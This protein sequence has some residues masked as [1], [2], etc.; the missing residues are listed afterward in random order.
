[1]DSSP[2]MNHSFLG[3]QGGMTCLW[4]VLEKDSNGGRVKEVKP[5]KFAN[6]WISDAWPAHL[7]LPGFLINIQKQYLI[8][9]K[10]MWNFMGIYRIFLLKEECCKATAIRCTGNVTLPQLQL[11]C[12]TS[13]CGWQGRQFY[14][15]IKFG[16]FFFF[17]FRS[18]SLRWLL[19]QKLWAKMTPPH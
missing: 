16:W 5:K 2:G 14:W 15:H 7:Q 8:K 13:L 4:T 18:S 10:I 3:C 6:F 19:L 17:K 1:M 12:S 11:L 9:E